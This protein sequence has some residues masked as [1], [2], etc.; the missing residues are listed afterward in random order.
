MAL[1]LFDL[2][3]TLINGDSDFEWG[4]FL[5]QKK[6]VDAQ[7]YKKKNDYFF[8]QYKKGQLDIFEY[9][10]FSFKP[11]AERNMDELAKLHV[12]FLENWILPIIKS[13]SETII[14]KHKDQGDKVIIITATNS[15]ITRPIAEYLGINELIATE[16]EIIN[17]RYTG[18]V[19]GTPCF[20]DGKVLRVNDWLTTNNETLKNSSF[21]SDSHNDLPLLKLVD[22]AI[23]VDPDEILRTTAQQNNWDIISLK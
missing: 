18:K 14:Q 8:E 16:P 13:G 22:K 19:T 5:V 20:Q 21:Y 11:L 6:L 4:N 10:A 12:E 3:N 9:S 17:D 7:E 2:D 15:F 23:A 1:A